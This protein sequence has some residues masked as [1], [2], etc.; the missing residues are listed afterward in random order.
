[1]CLKAGL[2]PKTTQQTLKEINI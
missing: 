1:M 2:I